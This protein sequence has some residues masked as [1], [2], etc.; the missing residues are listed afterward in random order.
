MTTKLLMVA[1][2]TLGCA[3]EDSA[4]ASAAAEGKDRELIPIIL[5]LFKAK[6]AA[7]S[8]RAV[9]AE[10][11][12]ENLEEKTQK[13]KQRAEKELLKNPPDPKAAL[14]EL[15]K[16]LQDEK[17]TEKLERK[18]EKFE[19]AAE[20][21]EKKEA[22][23]LGGKLQKQ[24]ENERQAESNAERE[25]A[26]AEPEERKSLKILKQAAQEALNHHTN[27]AKKLVKAAIKEAKQAV[28]DEAKA[29]ADQ[30]R[31]EKDEK[32]VL[33]F[34][35]YGKKMPQKLWSMHGPQKTLASWLPIISGFAAGLAIVGFVY[36]AKWRMRTV[37][38]TET[39]FLGL[40]L[41]EES[42]LE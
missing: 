3:S 31:A 20:K 9:A 22:K 24:V 19:A 8:A 12:S 28:A 34:W 29:R 21:E 11:H 2:L 4:P 33:D 18:A 32:K 10:T 26:R 16:L 41:D 37:P 30:V 25:E 6:F 1:L 7:N 23:Q 39:G 42:A 35:S 13:G 5:A 14:R 17:K 27:A 36:L 15:T 38:E 40:A